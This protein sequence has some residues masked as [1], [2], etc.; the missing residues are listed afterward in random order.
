MRLTQSIT[1]GLHVGA[2]VVISLALCCSTAQAAESTEAVFYRIFLADGSTLV[3]YGEY[4]RVGDQVIF[5]MALGADQADPRLHLVSIPTA[6]VDWTTTERYAESARFAHYTETRGESD[7]VLMSSEV[8]RALNEIAL[9][10]DRQAQLRIAEQARN[11]LR[12][13]P[14]RHYGYRANDVRQI[15]SLLDEAISEIRIAAGEQRFDLSFVAMAA[16]PS[17]MPLMPRST[18]QETIAQVLGAA[19]ITRVPA[20]RMSLLHAAMGLL[21]EGAASLAGEWVDGTRALASS[22]L[23]SELEIERAYAKLS[24]SMLDRAESH[25]AAAKVRGVEG[26]VREIRRQDMDLGARRPNLVSALLATVDARLAAAR[27]LRLERDRW[28]LRIKGYRSYQRAL[29]GPFARFVVSK[30]M[31]DDIRALAGPDPEAFTPLG[32][33]LDDA[34]STLDLTTPPMDLQAVHDL[35]VRAVQLAQAAV[36]V[37]REAVASGDLQTAWDASSAASGSLMLFA[38][39]QAELKRHLT[40]PELR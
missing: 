36:D 35:L 1:A 5:S 23:A 39:A 2:H 21:D 12:A 4:S 7:F 34:A 37:R 22:E 8:A 11:T 29:S 10:E 31:L 33:Q 6:T 32:R 15:V 17:S 28:A 18:L 14:R 19:R 40:I 38:Q 3:S 16:S 9:T 30:P 25:A 20:E 13:W 24:N 26:L 27:Q